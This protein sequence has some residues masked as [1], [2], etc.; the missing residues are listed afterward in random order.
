MTDAPLVS[1]IVPV[2]NGERFVAETVES[3]LAQSYRPIEVIVVNDGSTDGT[4][5]VL[6]RFAERIRVVYQENAGQAAARNH[7]LQEASGEF[8]AFLD[9][10]D[11]WL[12]EKL[13]RQM[14]HLAAHPD[15]AL[16]T[17]MMVN[18][19]EAELAEE[20]EQMRDT[21]HAQPYLAT[22]QGILA[23]R[24]VFDR[25]G[26]LD[27][28]VAFSDVREWLHRAKGMG[29]LVEHLDQV[30]VRRRIHANNLSRGRGEHDPALLLRLAERAL[31]R[32]RTADTKA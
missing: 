9:A 8:I 17:S 1:C 5:A 26:A 32:R 27:T 30:L 24:E 31:A 20:A 10:D 13:E 11:L 12:P 25:V 23:R 2:F 6:E 18:F 4:A 3:M 29:V 15:A 22:W 19:W 28:G 7:G 16:C 14:A 21:A